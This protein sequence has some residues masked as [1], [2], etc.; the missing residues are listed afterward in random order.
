[1]SRQRVRDGNRR[2]E[3]GSIRSL[4]GWLP[5]EGGQVARPVKTL[6][7]TLTRRGCVHGA[8]KRRRT[9]K[10]RDAVIIARRESLRRKRGNRRPAGGP[11]R[12]EGELEETDLNVHPSKNPPWYFAPDGP[13]VHPPSGKGPRLI[14]VHALTIDGGVPNAQVVC[15]ATTHTGDEHGQLHREP[16]SR[17]FPEPLLPPRPPQALIFMDNAPSH[18]AVATEAFPTPQTGNALL[19]PGLQTHHPTAYRDDMLTPERSKQCRQLCP[20]P[21]LL[22]ARIAAA[23]G[24]TMVRTPP[25]PP[26]LPPI[27]TCWAIPK[28]D[29]AA[30]CDDTMASLKPHLEAG[31][32]QVT[33]AVGQGL[34]TKVRDQED[35]DWMEDEED[36]NRKRL[37][38][39]RFAGAEK[40]CFE[41]MTEEQGTS[42]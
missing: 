33:P 20:E 11:Y 18:K 8:S 22:R 32:D 19:Q 4:G 27:E 37:D 29:G 42:P 31:L 24:P 16:F 13:G 30:R 2:G 10:E 34:I 17:W 39:E 25:D 12:P 14:M 36:E 3:S 21:T 6:W 28:E 23:A 35:K 1:M 38:D 41:L 5:P 40:E 7:R 26:E 15:P 9:L